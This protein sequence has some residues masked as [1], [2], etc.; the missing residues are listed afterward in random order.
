MFIFVRSFIELVIDYLGGIVVVKPNGLGFK[1]RVRPKSVSG[2]TNPLQIFRADRWK[3][4]L[5]P[6]LN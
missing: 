2:N 5:S 3:V 1:F 4:N 6:M